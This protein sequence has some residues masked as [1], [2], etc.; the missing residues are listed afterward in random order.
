MTIPR[1]LIADTRNIASTSII[2]IFVPSPTNVAL[3]Y[4]V[5]LCDSL[6]FIMLTALRSML[7]D[8]L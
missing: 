6:I 8:P 2:H 7:Q 4:M 1:K 3:N 5:L